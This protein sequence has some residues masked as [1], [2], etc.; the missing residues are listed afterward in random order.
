VKFLL[1]AILR[2]LEA[3]WTLLKAAL[4]AVFLLIYGIFA[5]HFLI[6]FLRRFYIITFHW[7]LETSV[8][9]TNMTAFAGPVVA[10]VI[11]WIHARGY[12]GLIRRVIVAFFLG[13]AM[14]GLFGLLFRYQMVKDLGFFTAYMKWANEAA[15]FFYP[16]MIVVALA[17]IC[18]GSPDET[19]SQGESFSPYIVP[20]DE[21][22]SIGRRSGSLKPRTKK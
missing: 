2:Q 17:L 13:Y 8:F 18:L 6:P 3:P 14:I 15:L 4:A 9:W 12:W 21:G 7:T 20:R 10:A 19:S 5:L 1:D 22:D 16:G 11:L